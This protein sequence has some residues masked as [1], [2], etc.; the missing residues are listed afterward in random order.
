V[1][2]Q[3]QDM[4]APCG[5]FVASTAARY[6][7]LDILALILERHGSAA[8]TTSNPIWTENVVS[9]AASAPEPRPLIEWLLDVALCPVDFMTCDRLA[10]RGDIETLEWARKRGI[11][12][13]PCSI[14]C[15]AAVGSSESVL[16]WLR[17]IQAIDHTTAHRVAGRCAKGRFVE[18]VR[19]V[20]AYWPYIDAEAVLADIGA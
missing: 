14:C 3:I 12:F 9:S 13:D 20:S 17:D 16:A 11:G 2:G 5:S 19:L 6:G 4:G 1:F 10:H 8:V 18:A 15:Q 7:R